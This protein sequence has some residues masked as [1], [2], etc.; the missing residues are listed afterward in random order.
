MPFQ[1][2]PLLRPLKR[3]MSCSRSTLRPDDTWKTSTPT[4][5]VNLRLKPN[6]SPAPRPRTDTE[7]KPVPGLQAAAGLAASGAAVRAVPRHSDRSGRAICPRS[8]YTSVVCSTLPPTSQVS[9]QFSRW[10]SWNGSG[11]FQVMSTS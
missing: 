1:T 8:T 5:L 9:V 6:F 7:R 10:A 4:G 3:A 2:N 11:P